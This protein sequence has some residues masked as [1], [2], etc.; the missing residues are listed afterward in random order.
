[1]C[2]FYSAGLIKCEFEADYCGWVLEADE[3]NFTLQRLTGSSVV[4]MSV[5]GPNQDVNGN[6]SKHFLLTT[7]YMS[8]FLLPGVTTSITSPTFLGSEHPVECMRFWFSFGV[9]DLLSP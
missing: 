3:S 4:E 5:E 7:N 6:E 8:Q 9:N 2:N 1:M